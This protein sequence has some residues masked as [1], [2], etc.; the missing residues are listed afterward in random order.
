MTHCSP[1]LDC[2][3]SER[4][5]MAPEP[6]LEAITVII[7]Y[8]YHLMEKLTTTKSSVSDFVVQQGKLHLS[9]AGTQ[10]TSR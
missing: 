6:Y 2:K 1:K 4:D 8:K 5:T 9:G 7:I 10:F 3:A